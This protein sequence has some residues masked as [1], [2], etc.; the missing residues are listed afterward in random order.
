MSISPQEAPHALRQLKYVCP[1]GRTGFQER[2]FA[3]APFQ[4]Q[5]PQMSAALLAGV[6]QLRTVPHFM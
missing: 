5:M 3:N 6:R 1:S 2:E 4:I